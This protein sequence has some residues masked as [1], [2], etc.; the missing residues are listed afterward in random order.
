MSRAD[1]ALHWSQHIQRWQNTS[2]KQAEYCRQ[3]SLNQS[4]F[5]YWK[6]KQ[7]QHAD[8]SY[9]SLKSG[10]AVAQVETT[11]HYQAPSELSLSLP[12]GTALSGIHSGNL[13]LVAQLLELLR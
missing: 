4:Q 10:F 1:I 11:T 12:D 6:H 2:L 3:H 9:H 5:S 8:E 13:N 7:T